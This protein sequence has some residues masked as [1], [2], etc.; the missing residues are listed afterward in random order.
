MPSLPSRL[1]EQPSNSIRAMF[2]SPR[3]RFKDRSLISKRR[4]VPVIETHQLIT[5]RERDLARSRRKE[6]IQIACKPR[7]L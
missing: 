2:E 3:R 7:E 4:G 6:C 5:K 1:F